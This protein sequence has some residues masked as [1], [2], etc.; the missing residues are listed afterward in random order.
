MLYF[1]FENELKFYTLETRMD[2]SIPT[3][4]MEFVSCLPLHVASP[5]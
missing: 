2:I 3:Q 1:E 5:Y 4:I